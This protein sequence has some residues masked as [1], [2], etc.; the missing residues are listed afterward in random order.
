LAIV[1]GSDHFIR[2]LLHE[3]DIVGVLPD[4]GALAGFDRTA[5][6]AHCVTS[7]PYN[8]CVLVGI[9]LRC[10]TISLPLARMH[11]SLDIMRVRG[12]SNEVYP[13]SPNGSH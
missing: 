7:R 8:G 9:I 5:S 6:H 11:R 1:A 3:P 2:R 12:P 4:N 13:C 10:E